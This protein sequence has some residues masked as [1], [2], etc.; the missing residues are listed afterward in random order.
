MYHAMMKYLSPSWDYV[1]VPDLEKHNV[2]TMYN[3]R[4]NYYEF[5]VVIPDSG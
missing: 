3:S 2:I 4:S 5:I 1:C